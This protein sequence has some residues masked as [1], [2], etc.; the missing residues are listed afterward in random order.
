MGRCQGC[1]C[2]HQV[3]IY[4]EGC[5]DRVEP[6]RLVV[7]PG[8]MVNFISLLGPEDSVDLW[9]PR[10]MK[11]TEPIHLSGQQSALVEVSSEYGV[12][13]YAV[14]VPGAD[15]GGF[16]EGGSPPRMIVADP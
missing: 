2:N 6:G 4:K 12:F 7:H 15:G 3:V 1:G 8:A 10:G 9:F 16:A 13:A 14:H 5:S 11:P